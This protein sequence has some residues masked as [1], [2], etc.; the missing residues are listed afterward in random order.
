M[1]RKHSEC[2]KQSYL[3]EWHLCKVLCVCVC[4]YQLLKTCCA[5]SLSL[6]NLHCFMSCQVVSLSSPESF[7]SLTLILVSLISLPLFSSA[8]TFNLSFHSFFLSGGGQQSDVC[9]KGCKHTCCVVKTYPWRNAG[10]G[11]NFHDVL[12]FKGFRGI[13]RL[14]ILC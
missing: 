11:L 13:C 7:L 12:V 2:Y 5:P 3:T 9:R 14:S 10:I 4:V 8:T 1:Q 6:S